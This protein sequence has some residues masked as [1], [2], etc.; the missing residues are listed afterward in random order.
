MFNELK[1]FN[2]Q[3]INYY[4]FKEKNPEIHKSLNPLKM[5]HIG[6]DNVL[7]VLPY[8]EQTGRRIII[9]KIGKWRCYVT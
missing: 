3:M 7:S 9:Y 8:R 6:D 1:Y 4:N 2:F 5:R